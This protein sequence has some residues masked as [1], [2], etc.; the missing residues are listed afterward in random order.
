MR[1]AYQRGFTIVELLIV[2]V[3][4][5][6]LAAITIVAYNGIQQRATI[7][8]LSSDLDNAN[9]SLK[10]FQV[11]NSTFPTTIDCSIADSMVNKCV[12]SSNGTTYQYVASN[13]T[14]PQTFCMTANNGSQNYNITQEGAPTTG[15]CPIVNL[16]AAVASS[17]PGTG[18]TWTDLSGNGNNASLSNG[19][20]YSGTNGGVLSFDGVSGYVRT[21]VIPTYGSFALSIWFK[22]PTQR[23]GDRLYWGDGT[24]RAI[25]A[26]SGTTGSLMWYIN[27]SVTNTG[28]KFSSNSTVVNQWNNV[29][30]QYTGSQAQLFING[31]Q[32]GVTA[33]ITGTSN[34]SGFN[35]GTNYDRSGNWYNGQISNM[36]F[37]GR[38]LSADE[39]SQNFN[40]LR[41]RYGI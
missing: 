38:S 6:I 24:N 41:G 26:N 35:L 18:T 10:L 32:D 40:A 17:Y 9:K 19:V 15:I 7:A 23:D 25:L 5:G 27:T 37:Y 30:L 21:S 3:I 1:Q 34:A 14:K 39:I 11:D 8:S 16:D 28:Y 20:S 33:N 12:K 13:V 31:V 29:V 4:I 36:R 2:I 22:T